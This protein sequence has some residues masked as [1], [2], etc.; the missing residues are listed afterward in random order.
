MTFGAATPARRAS[1]D[2]P[3]VLVIDDDT[4]LRLYVHR[5]LAGFCNVEQA[6]SASA[7][8]AVATRTTP[9][10]I[11]LD[12]G[13]PDMPGLQLLERLRELPHI[14]NT[15]ILLM[16]G[17]DSGDLSRMS[18]PEGTGLLFKPFDARGLR[19]SVLE[20]LGLDPG[21]V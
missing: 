21:P 10:L 15:P 5:R 2:R 17:R 12:L 3:V 8:L 1:G 4:D 6:S 16:T 13:L 20:S 11:L 18:V 7:A 14:R 19:S 9:S